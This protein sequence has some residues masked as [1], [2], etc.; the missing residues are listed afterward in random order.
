MAA[1]FKLTKDFILHFLNEAAA[2]NPK[3]L[4]DAIEPDVK[5]RIGS[6]KKDAIAKTGIYVRAPPFIA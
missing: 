5:W 4:I 6:E 1:S 2:G 3:P